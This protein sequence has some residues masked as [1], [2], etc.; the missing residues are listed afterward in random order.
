MVQISGTLVKI[1]IL[2]FMCLK[3]FSGNIIIIIGIEELIC[4]YCSQGFYRD[5]LAC[6]HTTFIWRNSFIFTKVLNKT[7]KKLVVVNWECASVILVSLV[8]KRQ[9]GIAF[10]CIKCFCCIPKFKMNQFN[11]FLIGDHVL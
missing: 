2:L 6:G 9:A 5:H 10:P 11:L 1:N 4:G 7:T 8:K 3:M